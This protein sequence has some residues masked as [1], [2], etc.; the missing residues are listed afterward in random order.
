MQALKVC[1]HSDRASQLK[2]PVAA[3]LGSAFDADVSFDT[4]DS[5]T[6]DLKA[7]LEE[8]AEG[9]VIAVYVSQQCPALGKKLLEQV[10]DDMGCMESKDDVARVGNY[11][12]YLGSMA[13]RCVTCG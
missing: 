11:K 2:E 3:I 7:F 9:P 8:D 10:V 4:R 1:A 12:E 6:A 13:K 5:V